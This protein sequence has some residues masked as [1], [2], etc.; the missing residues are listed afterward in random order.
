MSGL[1]VVPLFIF[2]VVVATLIVTALLKKFKKHLPLA[3][4]ILIVILLPFWDIFGA[5]L[6]KGYYELTLKPD[7]YEYPQRDK[8]GKI[9]SV[10]ASL[11]GGRFMKN[12]TD[13]KRFERLLQ[14]LKKS[15]IS[16][17]VEFDSEIY[18]TD[19]A[20]EDPQ[21]VLVRVYI[22]NKEKP[23]EIVKESKARYIGKFL[24][25]SKPT[26][27]LFFVVFK[28]EYGIYDTKNDKLIAKSQ[29]VS[30]GTPRFMDTLRRNLF[31]LPS[32][33]TGSVNTWIDL[34]KELFG[35]V[36]VVC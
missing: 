22:N 35:D 6:I 12:F 18:K 17:F 16:D 30:I 31:F 27:L 24:P 11:A 32:F 15:N 25:D 4:V 33:R 29:A 20:L 26:F 21:K 13:K 19:S 34:K 10:G 14:K 3:V 8:N 28:N 36:G 23:Y 1:I 2:Y 7:I 5:L 9:E